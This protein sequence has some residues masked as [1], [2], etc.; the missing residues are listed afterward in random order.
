MAMAKLPLNEVIGL[1]VKATILSES[2]LSRLFKHISEHDS[3]ILTGWRANQHDRSKCVVQDSPFSQEELSKTANKPELLNKLAN[4]NIKASLLALGYGVTHV[5]GSYIENFNTPQQVE[6][7]EDS[8]FVSNL[9]DS[10][11]FMSNIQK[12]GE[13]YCQDSVLIISKGG[14]DAYLLGTNKAE[15]PGH[16]NR[17][18]VGDLDMGKSAEFMTKVRNRPF[19]FHESKAATTSKLQTYQDLPKNQRMAVK[20][21]HAR[22]MACR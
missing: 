6:V 4:R 7:S 19:A 3:A 2:S 17:V 9:N 21:I 20:A 12:L 5:D 11:D 1:I 14:V 10:P 22:A 18:L 8:L 15:F 16:G 13:L